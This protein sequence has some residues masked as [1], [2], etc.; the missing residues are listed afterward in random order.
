VSFASEPELLLLQAIRVRGNASV[1][2]LVDATG[3]ETD[4]VA[5]RL[6]A[7]EREGWVRFRPGPV[8]VPSAAPAPSG[9]QPGTWTLTGDG[10]A[11]GERRAAAELD[12]AGVR[13]VVEDDY[14]RFR[15]LNPSLLQVCTDW[16]LRN[17]AGRTAPNDHQDWAYDA[18]VIARLVDIDDAI[19]P[20][21][22]QL[23]GAL[24]R[25]AGYAERF[26]RAL[27]R[28]R[29][30]E[31]DWFTRPTIDSYHTVWFELHENLL[32]TLGIERGKET[33]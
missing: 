3:L 18:A 6:D 8:G 5:K 28:V 11:E 13:P 4:D 19:Q 27:A 17:E 2:G 1:A 14:R 22:R 21:C 26:G 29:D 7:F 10:R 33:S 9:T 23:A 31:N 12:Q 24:D 15:D 25:F 32:A 20:L 30:G 16:Q